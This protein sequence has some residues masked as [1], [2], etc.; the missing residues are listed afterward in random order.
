M[1]KIRNPAGPQDWICIQWLSCEIQPG[2]QG[3]D[4][5]AFELRQIKGLDHIE[6]SRDGFHVFLEA[7]IGR[8]QHHRQVI[9]PVPDILQQ[10]QKEKPDF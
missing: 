6:I 3:H 4:D 7:V 8:A 2:F 9:E 1:G 10:V 5:P